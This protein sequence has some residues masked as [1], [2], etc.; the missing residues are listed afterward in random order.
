MW[1]SERGSHKDPLGLVLKREASTLTDVSLVSFL[2]ADDL[3]SCNE[4]NGK[5]EDFLRENCKNSNVP[6]SDE[7]FCFCH[8]K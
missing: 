3:T 4:W 6:K 5:D 2:F 8:P 1:L 7:K